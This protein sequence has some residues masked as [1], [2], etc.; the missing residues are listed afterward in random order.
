M[1]SED[2]ARRRSEAIKS[3]IEKLVVNFRP[4]GRKK[5]A[6]EVDSIHVIPK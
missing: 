5:P 4:A 3:I 6:F 2:A 1:E